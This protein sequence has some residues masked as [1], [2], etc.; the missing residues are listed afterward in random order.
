MIH[1]WF[2]NRTVFT[3]LGGIALGV[4]TM[5]WA[6][7]QQPPAPKQLVPA[8]RSF[9][10]SLYVQT[11]AEY[12]ASCLQTFQLARTVIEKKLKELPSPAKPFAIVSDLDETILD[13]SVYQSMQVRKN[14][15]FDIPL[16]AIWQSKFHDKIELVPGAKDFID[17]TKKLGIA[18]VFISNRD[19][20]YREQTKT[21]LTRL[22]IGI[23]DEKQ[24][25]LLPK[26][27]TTSNKTQRRT[28]AAADFTILALMGDNLRDF[29]EEFKTPAVTADEQSREKAIAARKAVVDKHQA[30]FGSEWFML[31]N[32]VY[33][34]WLAPLKKTKEDE[35]FLR[36]VPPEWQ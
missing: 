28:E 6:G 8:H 16:W 36:P 33:G 15:D 12:R 14:I 34:E 4:G 17:Q 30:K 1:R 23:T 13:N 19:E 10:S 32:P 29:D 7:L 2:S 35:S 26:N 18:H 21:A 9:D 20:E 24:L 3:F 31:P 27:A 5:A 22:G 11:S 25:K